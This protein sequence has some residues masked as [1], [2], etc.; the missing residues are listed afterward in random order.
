MEPVKSLEWQGDS[1]R[2]IDQTQLPEREVYRD[3]RT[4]EEVIEAIQKLRIRGAPAIGIAGAYAV[5]LAAREKKNLA[6]ETMISQLKRE[7]RAISSA[8]PTAVNLS[9]AVQRMLKAAENCKRSAPEKILNTFEAEALAI[10]EEDRQLCHLI[11]T[12]G[13]DFLFRPKLTILTHCNTGALATGGQG[14]A[15]GVIYELQRRGAELQVY[16]DETRPLLQGA[17]L[18]AWELKKAGIPVTV[19]CDNMAAALLS[20]QNIDFIIVG[21]DRI[22]ANGDTANKIGTLGLAVLARHF[23]IPFYVA[24]PYSTFDLNIPSGKEIPIEERDPAEVMQFRTCSAAPAGVRAWNPAFDVTPAELISGIITDRGVA[25]PPFSDS[26]QK[27][28]FKT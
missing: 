3:L 22:A 15:L 23:G 5:L 17:R 11:G 1:L 26:L 4:P 28:A 20:S 9:W 10:H 12:N 24:A 13:A 2:I 14:T 27:Q 21:A 19:I 16:V 8:R 18:T 7:A 6:P 25:R